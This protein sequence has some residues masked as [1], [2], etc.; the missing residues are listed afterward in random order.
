[1]AELL[2]PKEIKTFSVA[3]REKSFDESSYAR[4][5]AERFGTD[6]AE[7]VLAPE[8]MIDILPHVAR[9]L[10]EP[11]ADAS[12]IP[13]YLL[14]RF[15][16]R[17]VT[18]ALG[19]DGGDELFLGYPTFGAHRMAARY[20]K[21]PSF[22]RKLVQAA[23]QRLPVNRDNFSFDFK[24]KR[25]VHGAQYEPVLRHQVW[26]GAF[27]PP[28]QT[29]LLSPEVLRATVELDV[30]DRVRALHARDGFRDDYDALTYEYAKLYLGAGVLT[31][32]DRA[33]MAV[34]LEVRAPLL[35]REVVE[36]A[37][38]LPS[39]LKL[40]GATTK[41]LLKRAMRGRLP[42][43]VIDR[44]KKGFGIPVGHWIVGPLRPLFE[45]TLSEERIRKDGFFRADTVQ[46]LLREHIDGS[47][48]H[49]KLL[50]N[51]FMFQMWRANYPGS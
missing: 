45:E 21:V 18:V 23:V 11:L 28:Q 1:M 51:L 6:H 22:A 3:F 4:L 39:H 7:E 26:L 24:A 29:Q 30:Y 20:A 10:D 50:W 47:H 37:A 33:S 35:D 42:D 36:L 2:P 15:T 34:S 41:Y 32:V 8:V 9:T 14:S 43:E 46:R 48:D 31:K 49:R 19:G 44:P 38:A 12:I 17:H 40:R 13:T 25:F 27:D 16:R 5:V